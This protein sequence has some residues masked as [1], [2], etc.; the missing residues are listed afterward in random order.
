MTGAKASEPEVS[1]FD[2]SGKVEEHVF[3]LEITMHDTLGVDI[4]DAGYELVEQVPYVK[5]DLVCVKR[6]LVCV[7]GDLVCVKRDLAE[8]VPEPL[9]RA[10]EVFV[11]DDIVQGL[12]AVL[13]LYVQDLHLCIA[14]AVLV[15]ISVLKTRFSSTNYY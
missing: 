5:R 9:W 12:F 8:Q 10:R 13:H 1:D 2:V 7:K 14:L 4:G 6:D 11:H 3:W 15:Y